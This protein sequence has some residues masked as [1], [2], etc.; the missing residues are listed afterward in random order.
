MKLRFEPK[1]EKTPTK[2]KRLKPDKNPSMGL[3][4][5]QGAR[6]RVKTKDHAEKVK[7]KTFE[8]IDLGSCQKGRPKMKQMKQISIMNYTKSP[9]GGLNPELP[10]TKKRECYEGKGS[11]CP[12]PPHPRGERVKKDL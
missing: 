5:G 12:P 8:T 6:P 3:W 1:T 2:L 9:G 11:I 7:S 10:S 4:S